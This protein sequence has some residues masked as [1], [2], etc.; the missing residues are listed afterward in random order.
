MPIQIETTE[1]ISVITVFVQGIVS[2]LSPCVLPLVPLYMGY[3]AGGTYT[4]D[5][6]GKIQYPRK[7]VMLNTFFFVFG[8]TIAFFIL[9]LGVS[10]LRGFF[11]SNRQAFSIVAGA[12][13]LL[14]GLYQL[15]AFGKSNKLSREHRLPINLDKLAMG[16]IAALLMGFT[17]SFAW[18]P[19]VGPTLASVLAMSA[20]SASKGLGFLLIGVYAL[21]FIIPFLVVGLFTTQLL[22][23]FK[24]NP[25]VMRYAVVI[26]G[27]LMV[28]IGLYMIFTSLPR[29]GA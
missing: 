3:L 16:P 12:L 28:G 17:F 2:F 21:G 4:I 14:F 11:N 9:G 20:G 7:K 15:G 29:F 1:S 26:G 8:I 19:C 13:I 27:A 10:A 5:A 22:G 18:T 24:K 23:F 25:K 6:D